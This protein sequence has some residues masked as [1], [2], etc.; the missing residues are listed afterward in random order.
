MLGGPLPVGNY[1][2]VLTV[3]AD[4]ESPGTVICWDAEFD[5]DGVSD[6]EAVQLITGFFE[7]GL[8]SVGR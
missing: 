7:R 3:T 8:V 1:Q 2:A 5:A 6:E 4:G